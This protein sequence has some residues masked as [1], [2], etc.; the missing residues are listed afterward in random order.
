MFTFAPGAPF[1][2]ACCDGDTNEGNSCRGTV[3]VYGHVDAMCAKDL[4]NLA[5]PH[6]QFDL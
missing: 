6:E 4:L 1:L 3:L 5:S 2:V